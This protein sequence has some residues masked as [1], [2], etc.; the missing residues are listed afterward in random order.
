MGSRQRRTAYKNWSGYIVI[1]LRY[2][3]ELVKSWYFY[4]YKLELI[5]F[6]LITL[7]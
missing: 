3:K 5:I 4:M 7:K 1:F 6:Y 2:F